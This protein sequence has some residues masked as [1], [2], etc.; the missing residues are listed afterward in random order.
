MSSPGAPPSAPARGGPLLV[1]VLVVA[2]LTVLACLAAGWYGVAWYR[3][4]HDESLEIAQIREEVLRDARQA[5]I[6][7]NTLDHRSLQEDFDLWEQVT[8]GAVLEELHTNRDSYA[9]AV[10]EA[11]TSSTATI[12]ESAV[13]DLNAPSGRARV[14][15][16]VDVT[17]RP[18][19]GQA[20][21]VLQRLQLEMKRVAAIWK[22]DRLAP[23]GTA[24][25]IP[26]PCPGTS[27]DTGPPN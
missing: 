4:S 20:S 1:A 5:A 24:T 19:E 23:V 16:G 21:C 7:L 13:A 22:V 12:V 14:L 10:G 27:P 17:Y 18:E 26:G 11:R 15:V 3:V 8:T 9:A 6:N 2:L 25:P